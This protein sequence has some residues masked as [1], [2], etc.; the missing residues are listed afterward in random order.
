[1]SLLAHKIVVNII[2]NSPKMSV[3]LFVGVINRS[4]KQDCPSRTKPW[5][6]P[7]QRYHLLFKLGV[8]NSR[9]G[10]IHLFRSE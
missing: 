10:L 9:L 3:S 7:V 2:V 5:I 4:D 1:M 6:M 8:R